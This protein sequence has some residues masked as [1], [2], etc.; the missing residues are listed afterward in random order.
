MEHSD[1]F[2]KVKRYYNMGMWNIDRVRNAV[3]KRWINESEFTEITTIPYSV[4]P[5]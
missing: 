2:E 1:Q 4:D 3:L 5:M